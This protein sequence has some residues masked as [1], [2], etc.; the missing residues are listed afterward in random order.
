VIA[1]DELFALNVD[2]QIATTMLA[3][4]PAVRAMR[5]RLIAETNNPGQIPWTRR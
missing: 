5:S 3:M 4:L 1:P 2:A